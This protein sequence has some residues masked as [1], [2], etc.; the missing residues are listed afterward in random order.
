MVKVIENKQEK[1]NIKSV[2]RIDLSHTVFSLVH[3]LD[4]SDLLTVLLICWMAVGV[5]I[6]RRSL[7]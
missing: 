4:R 2:I 6:F 7:V 5:G 1:T 3:S